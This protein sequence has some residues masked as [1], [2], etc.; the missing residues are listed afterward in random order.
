MSVIEIGSVFHTSRLNPYNEA[1]LVFIEG[2]L[3]YSEI[4]LQPDEVFFGEDSEGRRV[5]LRGKFDYANIDLTHVAAKSRFVKINNSLVQVCFQ[6]TRP[7]FHA[8]VFKRDNP[9]VKISRCTF[10]TSDQEQAFEKKK[11][12]MKNISKIVIVE[13]D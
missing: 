13:D 1:R 3:Q 7:E 8:S 4:G 12:F 11:S 6:S 2:K 5:Q 9:C 10:F